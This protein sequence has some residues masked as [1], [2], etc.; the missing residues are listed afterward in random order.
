[1]KEI[2]F[3]NQVYYTQNCILFFLLLFLELFCFDL[4]MRF[5]SLT[6]HN[7]IAGIQENSCFI[8]SSQSDQYLVKFM[9][10]NGYISPRT[11]FVK[12]WYIILSRI[13]TLTEGYLHFH[14]ILQG[15]WE[16]W[17]SPSTFSPYYCFVKGSVLPQWNRHVFQKI[18]P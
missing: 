10:N 17:L 18:L 7:S 4:S 8:C 11:C 6:S 12:F 1:M 9:H 13:R 16:C 14:F 15:M 3:F 5:F 2:I